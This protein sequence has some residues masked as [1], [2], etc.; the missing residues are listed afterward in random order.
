MI[1]KVVL[2]EFPYFIFTKSLRRPWGQVLL[3]PA[4]E[5]EP[6]A[7]V[8]EKMAPTASNVALRSHIWWKSHSS[9]R[10]NRT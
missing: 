3:I 10:I 7:A 6:S 9:T 5:E 1:Y 2:C 8:L 4:T